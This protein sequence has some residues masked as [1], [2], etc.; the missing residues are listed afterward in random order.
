MYESL[1]DRRKKVQEGVRFIY[2][3]K[4]LHNN[5]SRRL[6][7]GSLFH[8]PVTLCDESKT[9]FLRCSYAVVTGVKKGSEG[10]V[11]SVITRMSDGRVQEHG[12]Q[13]VALIN[14]SKMTVKIAYKLQ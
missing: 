10:Y 12:I 11:R 3:V 9:K 7:Q 8:K 6:A 4:Q 14:S 1:G 5:L 2:F 13:K